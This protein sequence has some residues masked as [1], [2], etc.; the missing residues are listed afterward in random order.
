MRRQSK[1]KLAV[2]KREA[3]AEAFEEAELLQECAYCGS[4]GDKYHMD[5]HHHRGRRTMEQMLDFVWM[6]R[7][8]HD[9]IHKNPE[10]AK[11]LG[12]LTPE[13]FG[14]DKQQDKQ[15]EDNGT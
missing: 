14:K 1:S 2:L 4:V 6:H 7:E 13:F 3:Y 5:R 10:R 11:K 8:C 12:L 15:Q 9:Y